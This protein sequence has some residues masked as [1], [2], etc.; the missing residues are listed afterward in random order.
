MMVPTSGTLLLLLLLPT[1]GA[2][3]LQ[4]LP[5]SPP[6]GRQSTAV[7]TVDTA[8]RF[9]R[10]SGWEAN[11]QSGEAE[12]GFVGWQA[13]LMDLAANDLG[14]NRIRVE[15]RSGA[16]HTVDYYGQFRAG[17][18]SES[19]WSP[20]KYV[21]V[22]D[23]DD[24]ATI[25]PNG[26]KWTALDEHL[27]ATVVPLRARLAARGETLYLNLNYVSFGTSTA[28]QDPAEYAELML[29]AFQHM[30]SRYGF[31]PDAIE[32]ILEPENT[33][34]RAPRIGQAIAAAGARLAAAGFHPDFI[35]PSV[36]KVANAVPYLDEIVKVPGALTY[37]K[38]IAYHRYGGV[39]DA[40]LLAIHERAVRYGL[41]TSMLEHIG[42]DVED[43]YKDLTLAQVSAWQ[44]YTL[45]YPTRDNGAQYYYIKNGRPVA[46]QRTEALRQYFR[47]VRAGAYRVGA[48]SDTPRVRPVAFT[49][50]DGR[51]VVVLH[52]EGREVLT[53]KGLPAGYYYAVAAPATAGL[54][55]ATEI[56][57]GADFVFA[58]GLPSVVTVYQVP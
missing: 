13:E 15:L 55:Y 18:I 23:N 53:L 25:N 27:D 33:S 21:W 10:M 37:L 42:S 56:A 57:A 5:P 49:N 8:T 30:Q 34:W 48:A 28:Q 3:A 4:Q 6:A 20:Y 29:A 35:A 14:I 24:P 22:N 47:H 39:S 45:A 51:V 52:L 19:V 58:M 31:V 1:S 38:E 17:M 12:P 46:G 40:N 44:Q 26:F 41:R 54:V 7:V 9:Q 43:L 16:E 11:A 32:V 50:P 2:Q 36:M